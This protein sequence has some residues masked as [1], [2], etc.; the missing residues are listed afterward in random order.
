MKQI[1]VGNGMEAGV[2]Q[3]PMINGQAVEKVEELMGDALAKGAKVAL[4]ASGTR[5]AAPSSSRPS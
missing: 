2:T 3:G 1:R 5:W 4:A